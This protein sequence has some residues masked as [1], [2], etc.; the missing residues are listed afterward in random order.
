MIPRA[1]V[2]ILGLLTFS[3]CSAH[4]VA[5]QVATRRGEGLVEL[6]GS[7]SWFA[8]PTNL[9]LLRGNSTRVN[10]VPPPFGSSKDYRIEGAII[11]GAIIGTGVG[12]LAHVSCDS[13][14]CGWETVKYGLLGA[15]FGGLTGA[16]IGGMITKPEPSP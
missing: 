15:A 6:T 9:N 10:E 1:R 16:L 8:V 12:Y 13:G 3:L 11:G 2:V 4:Q 7:N 5:S 14:D